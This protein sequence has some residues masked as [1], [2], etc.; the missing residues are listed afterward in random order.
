MAAPHHADA[1]IDSSFALTRDDQR[2]WRLDHDGVSLSNDTIVPNIPNLGNNAFSHNERSSS[3]SSSNTGAT[4]TIYSGNCAADPGILDDIRQMLL[5]VWNI[6]EPKPWQ[7]KS[8][9][10]MAQD[11][12]PC[13]D[14][15]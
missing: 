10:L 6:S 13:W 12:Q 14:E 4:D 9:S 3:T 7:L 2:W 15:R 11:G 5:E 1:D 8:I